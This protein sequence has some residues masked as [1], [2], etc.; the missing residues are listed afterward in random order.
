MSVGRDANTQ[1]AIME[2]GLKIAWIYRIENQ[3]CASWKIIP[4]YYSRDNGGFSFLTTC[5]Y[6]NKLH[7][8]ENLPS[9]YCKILDYWHS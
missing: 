8:L 7:N 6:D 1:F 5:N 2:K 3:S 9:F 4:D